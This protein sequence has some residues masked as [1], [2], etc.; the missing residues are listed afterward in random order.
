MANVALERNPA[1]AKH[2][3]R[4]KQI[5]GI[6]LSKSFFIE[7]PA[8]GDGT[9]MVSLI[10]TAYL[11]EADEQAIA[12]INEGR[13]NC[14][15]AVH[16]ATGKQRRFLGPKMIWLCS[17]MPLPAGATVIPPE[18]E[19]PGFLQTVSEVVREH[20]GG[21]IPAALDLVLDRGEFSKKE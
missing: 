8:G 10:P 4:D 14:T 11:D 13:E 12:D 20:P 21:F 5:D 3:Q 16:V 7:P 19:A 1:C 9:S 18:S 2:C 6:Y 17:D 15:G